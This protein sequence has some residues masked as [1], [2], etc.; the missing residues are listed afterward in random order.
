MCSKRQPQ[1]PANLH[2]LAAEILAELRDQPAA[3]HIILGGGVALQHYCEYRDTKDID[4]WWRSEPEG[5]AER[6]LRQVMERVASRHGYTLN[7]RSWGD[8]ASLELQ[9]AGQTLFSFQ[10]AVRSVALEP[11]SPSAW[12]PVQLETLLDNLAA[13]M[14][15]LVSRGAPRDILDV[16]TVVRE[17]LVT[18]DELW[19]AWARKN[20]GSEVA[21]AKA[22]VL[23]RL[24]ELEAR[25]PLDSIDDVAR[26]EAAKNVRAWTRNHLCQEQDA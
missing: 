1:P 21:S 7:V 18:I 10:I 25:R 24:E 26:R 9:D 19:A 13:K 2:P 6:L 5:D 17:G 12:P 23:R 4:A 11:A 15:A 20:P 16:F 22:Q 14:N 8:T 3:C